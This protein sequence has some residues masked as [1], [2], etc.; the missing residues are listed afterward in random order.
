MADDSH[1]QFGD[2]SA[3]M[4]IILVVAVVF[5]GAKAVSAKALTF[6]SSPP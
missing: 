6:L 5:D 3:H 2:V 1:P 4:C